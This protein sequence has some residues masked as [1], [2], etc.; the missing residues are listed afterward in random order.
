M[1]LLGEDSD[2]DVKFTINK[3]YAEKYDKWRQ[4]EELQKRT[5]YLSANSLIFFL[6][7]VF[8]FN[9]ILFILQ[10]LIFF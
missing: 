5:Y 3:N 7:L 1:D 8:I 2:A 6:T 10:P 4:G 9:F